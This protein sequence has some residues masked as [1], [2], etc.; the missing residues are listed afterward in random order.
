MTNYRSTPRQILI[1]PATMSAIL[2]IVFSTI[3]LTSVAAQESKPGLV[4]LYTDGNN[5]VYLVVPTPDF[6]LRANESIHPQ[7]GQQ[8][9]AEW[10][11][12]LRIDRAGKYRLLADGQTEA[13][14][15]TIEVNSAPADDWIQL[16]TGEHPI[17]IQLVRR[18]E[19]ARLALL[20]ESEFFNVEPLPSVLLRHT[21]APP[22]LGEQESIEHGRF[23]FAELGCGNC[24]AAEN[25]D[26]QTRRGPDLSQVASRID[27][28]WI[29]EWLENPQHYRKSA[30]MPTCLDNPRDRADVTT[31]LM[32]LKSAQEAPASTAARPDQLESGRELFEQ[33]G[34]VKC[35]DKDNNLDAI[36]SKYSNSTSLAE[37][38]ANPHA[39]DP[40][41]RMPQLFDG[42]NERHLA[43]SVASYLFETK[44]RSKSYPAP[45]QGDAERGAKLF[46]SNGCASCHSA[47][48]TLL[49]TSDAL[50]GPAFGQS[51]GMPI[52]HF[53]DFGN[54][55]VKDRVTG[56]QEKVVGRQ[57][58]SAKDATRGSAFDFDGK[59]FIEL[60]HFHRPDTM[61]ISVWVNTE[62]GGSILT[63]GRP[64]GGQRGSRELRM[65]IGQDG[66]NSLC[67][68]E[69]N[70]DGGW[71]PVIVRPT[72][73]NLIDGKWHHIAVVRN[74]PS[75]QHYIDGKPQGKP[76]TA[77]AGSGDYTDRLLIG[78]LG[79]QQNPSNYFKGLID[80]LS[81]WDMALS[82]EQIAV[83]AGGTSPMT[84]ARPPLRDIQPFD[85]KAGCLAVE[86][87]NPLP[88][89]RLSDVDRGGLQR[90]LATVQ[91]QKDTGAKIAAIEI[92]RVAPLT[93]HDMRIRQ[94][95]C[96]ACHQLHD[97]NV[98]TAVQETDDGRIIRVERP[99][100]LTGA[101]EKLTAAWLRGV[102]VEKKRNRPWLNLRMPHF[103]EGVN[104]MP[105]LLASACGV[106][107][108]EAS[109]VP[110]RKLADAGLL[111][112]GERRGEVSCIS[113]HDYRGI[114][115]RKD[116]VVPAPDLA[117]AGKTI[118]HEWFDRWMHN[119]SRLQPGTSMPQLFLDVSADERELRIAQLWSALKYQ[120]QLPLPKGVLDKRTE[121]TRIVVADAPV[122]F[123]MATS[124]PVGQIDRAINVGIPGGFNFTYDP[125]ECRLRYV[126]KGP[127]I[128]AG[129]AWNGRGGNPV[130]AG[131]EKL[132]AITEGHVVRFGDATDPK[133]LRFL[134][135][136]LEDRMPVFRYL[137]DGTS[138]E[139]RI[140]I[141]ESD[142]FQRFVVND[143]PN[144]VLYVGDNETS[145]S[146]PTGQRDNNV[147]RF[148]KAD[149]VEFTIKMPID[150]QA[151]N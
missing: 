16:S 40:H 83:L 33:I 72:D 39:V 7:I 14:E 148:P 133:P 28:G 92:Y 74:G 32:S 110:D 87:K 5:T 121:G 54:G 76:G 63:W 101:G 128:D 55:V 46:A 10:N 68:G 64:G 57:E 19:N 142:V 21:K 151:S 1:F 45:P 73:V 51:A 139:Q 107:S 77:Q 59:S 129:P 99:P 127:F 78:A 146:S 2:A 94:F 141:S 84:M 6:R 75:I 120:D 89:Y 29:Y 71:K 58:F 17:K 88:N 81:V 48:S 50:V 61:T 12:V 8:F 135:Y 22:Q 140:D 124:T 106:S 91:P 137:V 36:G 130:K 80:D 143:P 95:R 136:R 126:W 13:T 115:R 90:F 144:D 67:Y 60:A 123:R 43:N 44:R 104:D 15:A 118:R 117:D 131:S 65:N 69:Y 132:V 111:M 4:A 82:A 149:V 25:W 31:F 86:V 93:T 41:G 105:E 37:F 145:F 23:L 134:G 102:L 113:C 147:I 125:V 53:W 42:V 24:H 66:K 35:H 119:P 116:G 100:L 62:N 38:I 47:T 114:N 3:L 18:G 150:G 98:Q 56:R 26:L 109:Q 20:W 30:I 79:L 11:G 34:C 96:T 85:T 122:I 103:G 52:R 49:K 138:V 27:V 112:I 97:K 108:D 9:A 70:S